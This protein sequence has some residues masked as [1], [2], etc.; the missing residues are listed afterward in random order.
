MHGSVKHKGKAIGVNSDKSRQNTDT[1]DSL[2]EK[3][4]R[5]ISEEKFE[6]AAG[7][8]DKIKEMEAQK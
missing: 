7:V 5:L 6:E 4:A 8:R 3:L 2:K 1:V